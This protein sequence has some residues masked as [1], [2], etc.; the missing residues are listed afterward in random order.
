MEI[1]GPGKKSSIKEGEIW[2]REYG[3]LGVDFY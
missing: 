2:V 1:L 3:I